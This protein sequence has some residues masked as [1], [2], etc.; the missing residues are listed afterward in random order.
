MFIK[1]VFEVAGSSL[2]NL[3]QLGVSSFKLIAEM[4]VASEATHG[5][6]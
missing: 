5:H 1:S 3:H 2:G 4:P 6:I